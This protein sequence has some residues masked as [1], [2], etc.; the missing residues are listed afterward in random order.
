[1]NWV[2]SVLMSLFV[3]QG[4]ICQEF[5]YHTLM[6]SADSLECILEHF[7]LNFTSWC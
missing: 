3:K 1:M 5:V 4:H 2:P 6:F 7:G